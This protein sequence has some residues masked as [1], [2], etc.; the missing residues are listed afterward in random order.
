MKDLNKIGRELHK[1]LIVDYDKR[2]FKDHTRNGI[3]CR[4]KGNPKDKGLLVL[5]EILEEMLAS[6]L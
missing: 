4:W 5:S 2:I 1:T 3:E 6:V